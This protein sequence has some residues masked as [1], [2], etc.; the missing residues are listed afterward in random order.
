MSYP[1]KP[2]RW[3]RYLVFWRPSV[4]RDIDAELRFHFDARIDELI[5]LGI[6]PGA[7]HEQA[8]EEFGDVAAVRRD[9]RTIGERMARRR[10][11]GE[12]L[13]GLRQDVVYAAR[14]LRASPI[15]TGTIVL[16]L[17]LGIGVNTAMFSL[18][19][20]IFLRQPA[21]VVHPEQVHRLYTQRW[22]A[23]RTEAVFW[24]GFDYPHYS[25]VVSALGDRGR[26]AIYS[27]PERIKIAR[28][29]DA[30]LASTV[31]ASAGY[32][33]L[34][35][36]R[37]ALGRFYTAGDD[38]FGNGAHVAVVSD[39]FWRREL[40]GQAGAIGSTISL[41]KNKYSVIGVAPRDFTGIDLDAV[42]VWVPIATYER[43]PERWWTSN[44]VNG[45]QIIMRLG[46]SA[47]IDA[48]NT[49]LTQAFRE[50]QLYR[51]KAD[52]ASVARLGPL[53]AARGPGERDQEVRIATRI[54]GVTV[55]V[56]LIACANV[57][58]LLLARTVR[59]RREIAVRLAMGISRARLIRLLLA[60]SVLLA[61]VAGAAAVVAA[62]WGG[63]LLRGLLLPDV[64]WAS[65]PL[66]WRVL[67]FTLVV[68][69]IVGILAGLIPALQ[70]SDPEL[71]RALKAGSREGSPQ[72]SRLRSTLVAAQAAL[73]VLL[74]VGAALFVKS[75]RNV[76]RLDLGYTADQLVFAELRFDGENDARDNQ[77]AATLGE[78]AVRLR[79]APGVER[80]ALS[81]D[82]PMWSLHFLTYFADG[83]IGANK[84]SATY[85]AVSPEFFNASGTRIRKGNGLSGISGAREVVLNEAF[86]NALWP[87]QNALGRC[88]RFTR[89]D[90]PCYVVT[91]VAA[92]A[93]EGSVVEDPRPQFYLSLGNV[94]DRRMTAG[95]IIVRAK[96]GAVQPV[97]NEIRR[98]LQGALPGG[99]PRIARMSDVLEPQ[100]RPWRLGATLF[101]VFG[102]LALV[103]A[104]IGIY[105]SVSYG[106]SQ[107]VHEFG[108]RVALGART[109]DVIQHVVGQGVRTVAFGIA[110]GVVLTLAAGRLVASLLYGVSPADPVAM[111]AVVLLLLGVSIVAALSPAWRAARVDPMTALRTD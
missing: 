52:T 22:F 19:D 103:V 44:T 91:G 87:G 101:T 83:F 34:L 94:P 51:A 35:G 10:Q 65:T 3:R 80:V 9:L 100:Y 49:R 55:I 110:L 27:H 73:S 63:A 69:M 29:D 53:I 50:P 75:L 85:L 81:A 24:P 106:V 107:R 17:A 26:A 28:G 77:L 109:S 79:A 97:M 104:A 66:H 82:R 42:D 96:P 70:S 13:A 62:A 74:L 92:N 72:R 108:V 54:V 4:R 30:P 90:A 43:W 78:L 15:V 86:A 99:T 47:G 105:S 5:A 95:T 20:I 12:W 32:F 40:G 21:G 36:V 102:M 68:A 46:E 48:V 60:E 76:H 56:L 14:S 7:A 98:T 45:F 38:Q 18:I 31:Y 57:V 16:T 61:A 84:P 2:E 88:L 67:A 89:E 25:A 11:R 1:S 6:D 8:F 37:P 64:Q 23:H 58:N 111:V 41:G 33:D 71:T 39:A 93:R 59:R